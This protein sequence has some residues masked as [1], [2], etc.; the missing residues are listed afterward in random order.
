MRTIT[1]M[2]MEME[3][4]MGDNE[5]ENEVKMIMIGELEKSNNRTKSKKF[6]NHK[7]FLFFPTHSS[8]FSESL[9]GWW[10]TFGEDVEHAVC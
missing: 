4:E 7:V 8:S 2:I 9:G 5:N 1:I 3:M 6:F 10:K